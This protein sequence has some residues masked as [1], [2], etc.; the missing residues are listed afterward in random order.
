MHLRPLALVLGVLTAFGAAAAPPAAAQQE[1][2]RVRGMIESVDADGVVVETRTGEVLGFALKDDTGVFAVTPASL[3]DI[4]EGKYVGLTSIEAAGG[5][6]VALEAHV[7]AEDLR[8][9]AEGHFP[10]D[11]VEEP[12]T[13]TN[14]TVAE[15]KAVGQQREIEVT[16]ET[17][18]E[19]ATQTI[20]L[21]PDVPIVRLAKADRSA[22]EAGKRVFLVVEGPRDGI[23][24]VNAAVVGA[25]GTTPP[26]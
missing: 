1:Q 10:W 8:G 11:L 18:G 15:V 21:P 14:A 12:N 3:E 25:E 4:V 2:F 9:L 13:M 20:H 26:M 6:R 19:R 17:D 23:P 22:L 5:K 24:Q 7:F 16:Y